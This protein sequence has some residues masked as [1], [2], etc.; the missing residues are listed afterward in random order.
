MKMYT[1]ADAEKII[2]DHLNMW[3]EQYGEGFILTDECGLI[4][5]DAHILFL[6]IRNLVDKGLIRRRECDAVAYEW[7]R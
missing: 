5:I 1:V 3:E 6:A 7:N 2:I 4:E